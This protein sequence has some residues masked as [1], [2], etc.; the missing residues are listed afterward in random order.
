MPKD[1]QQILFIRLSAIGDIVMASGLP[2]SIKQSYSQYGKPVELTWLVEAPYAELVSNH[3]YVDHVIAW[4]KK[5]WR[6][7][8]KA[9]KYWALFK[10]IKAF[11]KQLREKNFKVAI[12]AQGLLKSAFFAY[13]SGASE[14][15]GF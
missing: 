5:E 10:T 2:S 15:I 9:K 12:E 11:R 4:P 14:R 6:S 3:P 13:I 8:L 1:V 7:L